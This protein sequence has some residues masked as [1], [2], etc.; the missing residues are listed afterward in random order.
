MSRLILVLYFTALGGL[1]LYGLFGLL[2]FALYW[3]HRQKTFPT[4]PLP[5]DLPSVT[6][7]LPIYNEPFVVERLIHT[8]V[9]LHYPPHLLQIQVIDDSTDSTTERAARLVSYYKEKG[10]NISLVHRP[11]REGYK[12]GA[13]AHALPLAS[14]D[15]IAIFD[16][17]FQPQPDFLQQTMPHFTDNPRLG[18][19]QTR[20]GHL[21]NGR[22]PLTSAQAIAL[23]K[24][25]AMEQTVRHRANLFPKFNGAGGVW[26]RACLEDAGGWESDTVCEDLCLSTRAMLRHWDCFFLDK[27]ETPAELP[28]TISAYKSQQARWAKGSSQCL[29]KYGRSILAAQQHSPLARMYALM[30]MSA[31]STN[32]FL[33]LLLL[34]QIPLLLLDFRFSPWLLLF[35]VAGIG[36]PLLFVMSQQVLYQDWLW[37]LRHFPTMVL[38]AIGLAPSNGRAILQAF[39]AREHTFVRTPKEGNQ[40]QSP[41]FELNFDWIFFVELGLALYAWIGVGFAIQQQNY[42][43]LFFLA[44]CACAYSTIILLTM[45]EWRGYRQQERQETAVSPLP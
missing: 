23:D 19:V 21:N 20:W 44:S 43:P 18:M 39:S 6:V 40:T 42:G 27:V 11:C 3:R 35:S 30:S 25:F 9:S 10:C 41:L 26:R 45:R 33:I 29:L 15:F 13:L 17:D 36:Q 37:R 38:I 1:A 34:L 28:T 7:Q 22:S 31:Y 5:T 2:T 24:H 12:A 14:G 32:I 4:P 8:A 16:A